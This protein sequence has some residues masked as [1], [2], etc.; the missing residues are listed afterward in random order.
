M[1]WLRSGMLVCSGWHKTIPQ[2]GWLKQQKFIS[3]SGAW[4]SKINMP[5]QLSSGENPLPGFL[6]AESAHW[7]WQGR[8]GDGRWGGREG[9][10]EWAQALWSPLTR[11]LILSWR[12]YPHDSTETYLS[13]KGPCPNTITMRV[14][15]PAYEFWGYIIQPTASGLV[16]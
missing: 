1:S 8:E 4:K 10:C 3:Q 9:T 2:T 12:S 15:S 7:S 5:T 6:L 13:S 14:R 16:F 11:A